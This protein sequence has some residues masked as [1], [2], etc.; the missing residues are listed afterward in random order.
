MIGYQKDYTITILTL[1]GAG[2]NILLNIILIPLLG[3]TG[4]IYSKIVA[5]LFILISKY[6]MQD[7]LI[8]QNLKH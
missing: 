3:I 5:F 2:I 8:R 1:I 6:L 7:K 4:A